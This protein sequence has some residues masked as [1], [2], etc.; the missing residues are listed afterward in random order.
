MR[1]KIKNI[2]DLRDDLI[3]VYGSLRD[4]KIGLK[5]AKQNAL[6]A[7]TI[8]STAKVQMD[9]HAFTKSDA[10]IPFLEVK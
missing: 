6:L 5:E 3:E 1:N 10:K 8:V 7:N 4:G 2:G 9:Y